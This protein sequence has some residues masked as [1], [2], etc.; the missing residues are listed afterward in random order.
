MTTKTTTKSWSRKLAGGLTAALLSTA[1]LAGQA[2]PAHASREGR[3]NSLIVGIIAATALIAYAAHKNQED[4]GWDRDGYRYD[5][6]RGRRPHNTGPR[7]G[8]RHY[9]HSPAPGYQQQ[10][11]QSCQQ[12]SPYGQAYQ[13]QSGQP[14]QQQSPYQQTGPHFWQHE[15]PGAQYTPIY[16]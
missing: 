7:N 15:D 2:R 5:A 8:Y 14:W 1:L 3:R 9:T 11:Q 16:R 6:Y 13:Q 10:W 4:D 12:Q